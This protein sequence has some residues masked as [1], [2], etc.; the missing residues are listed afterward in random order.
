MIENKIFSDIMYSKLSPDIHLSLLLINIL[1]NRRSV[2]IPR[3]RKNMEDEDKKA[4][5]RDKAKTVDKN[6]FI[7]LKG[8]FE[9]HLPP[10]VLE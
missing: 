3:T 6:I 1:S 8:N 10:S 7:S 4:Y 9:F 2:Q 5:S